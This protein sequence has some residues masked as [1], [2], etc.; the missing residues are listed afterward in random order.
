VPLT[1]VEVLP[2][3]SVPEVEADAPAKVL[4]VFKVATTGQFVPI[5]PL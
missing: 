3:P 5:L 2:P 1:E 4:P